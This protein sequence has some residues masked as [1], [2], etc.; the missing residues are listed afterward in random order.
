MEPEG[1]LSCSQESSKGLYP[2][3]RD[4]SSHPTY[5]LL[6]HFNIII[7]FIPGSSECPAKLLCAFI[8][9]YTRAMCPTHLILFD[10]I[11]LI[12]YGEEYQLWSSSSSNFLKSFVTSS[13]IFPETLLWWS[14]KSV[15]STKGPCLCLRKVCRTSQHRIDRVYLEFCVK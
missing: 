9:S 15:Y 2:E 11:T 12:T 13:V 3:P 1:S 7:P 14:L 6:I 4:S 10:L 8:I 5:F